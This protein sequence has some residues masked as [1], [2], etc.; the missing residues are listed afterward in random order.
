M[1]LAAE[2]SS[3]EKPDGTYT[4]I[5]FTNGDS[6]ETDSEMNFPDEGEAIDYTLN[7][8]GGLNSLEP[9]G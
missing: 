1:A 6:Y 7:I 9:A 4:E 5:T 2:V 3:F 8:D